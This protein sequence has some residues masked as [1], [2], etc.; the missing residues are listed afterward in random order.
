[1]SNRRFQ[2]QSPQNPPISTLDEAEVARFD[3]LAETWWD[4]FAPLSGLALLDI[5]CGGGL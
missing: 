3:R 1:M 5:G 2:T 4:E